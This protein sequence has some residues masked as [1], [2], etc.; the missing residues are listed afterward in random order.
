VV[1]AELAGRMMLE[2]EMKAA[3]VEAGTEPLV[4]GVCHDGSLHHLHLPDV[5]VTRVGSP[6]AVEKLQARKRVPK[7]STRNDRAMSLGWA[8]NGD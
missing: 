3:G 2:P 5:D 7:R 8:E 4:S 1:V 6:S